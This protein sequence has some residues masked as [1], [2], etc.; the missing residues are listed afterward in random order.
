MRNARGIV[1]PTA[2]ERTGHRP[3]DAALSRRRTERGMTERAMTE[4]ST[5]THGAVQSVD[6]AV[7]VLETIAREDGASMV[8]LYVSPASKPAIALWESLGFTDTGERWQVDDDDPSTTWPKF[9]R[10]L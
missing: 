9:A 3:S 1:G 10:P 4:R 6:R 8:T 7:R 5:P 2:S